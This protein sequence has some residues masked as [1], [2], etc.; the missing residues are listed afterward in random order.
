MFQEA[1]FPPGVVN[2]VTGYGAAGA[3][4]SAHDDVD[5][6]AFTG[7]TEV[8]EKVVDAARGNLKKASLE[9]GGKSANVVFADADFDA[10]VTGSLNAWLFN[11]GQSCVA[12]TRMFVEDS[13]FDDFTAAV[14]EAAGQV[15]I[16]PGID[17]AT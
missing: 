10:A 3:A 5:K 16:G 7:S 8:G 14:A 2:I 1:G 15:K 13:I 4:L 17:P 12:G 6:I 9:L 11:H